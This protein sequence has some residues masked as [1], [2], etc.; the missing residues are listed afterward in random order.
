MPFITFI[1]R[2]GKN[3]NI[4]YGKYVTDY[5]SDDHEGLDE[6]IKPFILEGLNKYRKQRNFPL[7]K[8][9]K[10]MVGIMSFS[11]DEYIPT[12]SSKVEID[13]FHF[14]CINNTNIHIKKKEFYVNGRMIE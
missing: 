9:N 5:I 8:K 2:V 13:C 1:Y 3:E 4:Y 7:L 14:Y 10:L 6:E 11:R 12:Y